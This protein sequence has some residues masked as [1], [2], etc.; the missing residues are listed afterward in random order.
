MI[1]LVCVTSHYHSSSLPIM[2]DH[3]RGG[4]IFTGKVRSFVCTHGFIMA[5]VMVMEEVVVMTIVTVTVMAWLLCFNRQGCRLV[6]SDINAFDEIVK[7]KSSGMR[8][9]VF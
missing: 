3:N 6:D 9:V 4:Q 7:F 2:V 8:R 5:M 1:E